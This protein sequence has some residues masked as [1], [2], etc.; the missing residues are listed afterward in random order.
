MFEAIKEYTGTD[1]SNMNEDE[2]R[3]LCRDHHIHVDNTMGKGKLIDEL[4]SEKCEHHLF[5][6]HSLSIT[7]LK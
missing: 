7:R 5:N 3:T 6:Q 1:V 2:L 4:F